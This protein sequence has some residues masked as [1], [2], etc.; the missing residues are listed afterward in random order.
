MNA[1]GFKVP[2]FRG[3][4]L[5]IEEWSDRNFYKA[6]HFHEEY[7]L[8]YIFKGEGTLVVGSKSYGFKPGDSYLFGKNLPHVFRNENN[9]ALTE[10]EARAH[11]ISVFFN[12][13]SLN[14]MLNG[15]PETGPIVE[16]IKKADLGLK[17]DRLQSPKLLRSMS[18]LKSKNGFERLLELLYILEDIAVNGKNECL[19][20]E[21]CKT[22]SHDEYGIRKLNEI[23]KF[24]ENNHSNRITL[25]DIATRFNMN[26]SSFCRFFKSRT[27]KTF[28]QFLIELRVAKACELMRSGAHN[29]SET[30]F[31]TGFT[32]LSNF[33]RQFKSVIG[34]TPTQYRDSVATF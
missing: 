21:N 6:V 10:E 4:S 8:T 12:A 11:Y 9:E 16:L 24:M 25:E 14:S 28:S 23:F 34:M 32:N 3:K 7:Q 30:C 19:A 22:I 27:Q 33:H 13:D 18:R 1:I 2:F 29:A 5:Y 20:N 31:T 17:L 15:V 26:P